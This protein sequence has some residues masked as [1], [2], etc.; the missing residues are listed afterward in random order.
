MRDKHPKLSLSHILAQPSLLVDAHTKPHEIDFSLPVLSIVPP[1]CPLSQ[2]R[3][4]QESLKT[5]KRIGHGPA[6]PSKHRFGG[7]VTDETSKEPEPS[8]QPVNARQVLNAA[9]AYLSNN[10]SK[11]SSL[12]A[13]KEFSSIYKTLKK[14]TT[15]ALVVESYKGK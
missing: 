11:L 5:T 6:T 9:T 1:V 14:P 2:F 4:A 8:Y 12:D 10:A 7:V 13:F 15:E 3:Q